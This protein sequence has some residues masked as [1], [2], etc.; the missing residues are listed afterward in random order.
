MR[1]GQKLNILLFK[2]VS[3]QRTFYHRTIKLWG[4][5]EPSLKLSQSVHTFKEQALR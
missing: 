1:S 5:L 3:R 2:T 4:N